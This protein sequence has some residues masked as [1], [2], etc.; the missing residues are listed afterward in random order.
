[1]ILGATGVSGKLAIQIAKRLGARRV[2]AAG[3][4]PK[5]LEKLRGLG[6]DGIISLNQE[7]AAL[8]EAIRRERA[9][10]DGIDVIAD[11]LWGPPAESLLEALT[12]KGLDHASAR[13]RYVQI[14]SSAGATVAMPAA[15]LR[16]SGL[17]MMGSGFG[18][19]SIEQIM[20][21]IGE[22]L[23]EAARKPF[24]FEIQTAALRDIESVW[25]QPEEGARTVFVV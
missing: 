2:I 11:Y 7:R 22:F 24:E 9:A 3:R 16:S 1:M 10:A 17:E 15:A 18:S 25:N 23:S 12:Q 5:A 14:G 19:A 21:S 4:N 13:V 6:A 20:R 8:V